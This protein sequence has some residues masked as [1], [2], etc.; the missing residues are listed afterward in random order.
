MNATT[1]TST[2]THSAPLRGA[3]LELTRFALADTMPASTPPPP[4]PA[5]L[6]RP[7]AA[8]DLSGGIFD[9]GTYPNDNR[10]PID[11][12]IGFDQLRNMP[13]GRALADIRP[14]PRANMGARTTFQMRL[15]TSSSELRS[16]LA[17]SVGASASSIKGGASGR[18]ELYRETTLSRYSNFV[19]VMATVVFEAQGIFTYDFADDTVRRL[20]LE[21]PQG[22][23][24]KY[25]TEFIS[26]IITGGEFIA[27]Y[28]LYAETKTEYEAQ[29]ASLSGK[30]GM[31]S[32]SAEAQSSFSEITR[33]RASQVKIARLGPTDAVPTSP[34]GIVDY[35]A[36]FSTLLTPENAAT[37]FFSTQSYARAAEGSESIDFVPALGRLAE[38]VALHERLRTLEREWNMVLAFPAWFGGAPGAEHATQRI[39]AIRAN[40]GLLDELIAEVQKTPFE[41]R[42]VPDIDFPAIAD[43]PELSAGDNLALSVAVTSVVGLLQ[44]RQETASNGE[45]IGS[46]SIMSVIVS[47]QNPVAGLVLEY[48]VH[49][50]DHADQAW[51]PAG[52]PTRY[53]SHQGIAFRLSGPLSPYYSVR[54]RV[55]MAGIGQSGYVADGV[56]CGTR[57]EYRAITQLLVEIVKR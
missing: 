49:L 6:W 53:W 44:P 57:G 13:A 27:L 56:Y 25:G 35:A 33:Y 43:L 9:S 47:F 23:Y 40:L 26:S 10:Y 18:A 38:L 22:F 31:W 37:L 17:L 29:K 4:S 28:E 16:T 42:A 52:T 12:G 45:W 20:Y 41:T 55:H 39:G 51:I 32:S 46:G 21:D 11:L 15:V 50:A 1:T 30:V 54:Y 3:G 24:E 5:W 36:R 2:T 14:E 34:E 8:T 19:M 48:M 7:G